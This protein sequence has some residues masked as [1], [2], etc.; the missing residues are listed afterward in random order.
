MRLHCASRGS[1]SS[2]FAPP[3]LT[4]PH[5]SDGRAHCRSHS[6]GRCDRGGR[7]GSG[8]SARSCSCALIAWSG[9][10]SPPRRGATAAEAAVAEAAEAE[11]VEVEAEVEAAVEAVEVEGALRCAVPP[12]PLRWAAA[13]LSLCREAARA[14]HTPA[15]PLARGVPRAADGA[16]EPSDEL[17]VRPRR[18]M[19]SEGGSPLRK[20]ERRLV[21]GGGSG[22]SCGDG[23]SSSC[24]DGG[25]N[26]C[27]DGGGSSCG[28]GGGSSCGGGVSAMAL[29][30]SLILAARHGSGDI[31]CG[32]GGGGH[33]GGCGGGG[34]EESKPADHSTHADALPSTRILCRWQHAC[35]GL[36]GRLGVDRRVV[37]G[38]GLGVDRRVIAHTAPQ[39]RT[40]RQGLNNDGTAYPPGVKYPQP[41]VA[42]YLPQ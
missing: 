39:L 10:L 3:T 36:R 1:S 30:E 40:E 31:S 9:C 37:R 24:G 4:S 16:C 14:S 32:G 5:R 11:A 15:E 41:W 8:R 7:F 13:T 28:D 38:G 27:G 35:S 12:L 26:S 17:L 29:S 21:S 20:R 33:G 19:C 25:S 2:R 34:G 18:R 42:A 22:S 6:C 23:G